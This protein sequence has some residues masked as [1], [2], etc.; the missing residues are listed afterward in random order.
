M[1]IPYIHNLTSPYIYTI[2]CLG[3]VERIHLCLMA[4]VER[5]SGSIKSKAMH[6]TIR[7][8]SKTPSGLSLMCYMCLARV[9]KTK[10]A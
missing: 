4:H 3:C 6:N 9:Q 5:A 8:T 1:L 2:V 7:Y 10:G